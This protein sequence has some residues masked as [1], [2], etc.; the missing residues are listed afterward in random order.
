MVRRPSAAL[1]SSALLTSALRSCHQIPVGVRLIPCLA[2]ATPHAAVAGV[3]RREY[4][5]LLASQP[6]RCAAGPTMAV[7]TTSRAGRRAYAE[8]AQSMA[9]L[10]TADVA[11]VSL[12]SPAPE[13]RG[14][15][16]RHDGFL[17]S[18]GSPNR[19]APSHAADERRNM[20]GLNVPTG[21]IWRFALHCRQKKMSR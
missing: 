12:V 17:P 15:R 1:H 21:N 8:G 5:G 9:N 11:P 20:R 16:L 19:K 10:A 7:A 18:A 13:N 14:V 2:Q 6:V 3:Q 4:V